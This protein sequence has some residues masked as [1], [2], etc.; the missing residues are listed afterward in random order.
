VKDREIVYEIMKWAPATGLTQAG[1]EKAIALTREDCA[2]ACEESSVEH[3]ASS[4][5]LSGEGYPAMATA[6]HHKAVALGCMAQDLR[7]RG[8]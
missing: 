1:I 6:E 2:K 5:A 7:E 4:D 8:K 3:S